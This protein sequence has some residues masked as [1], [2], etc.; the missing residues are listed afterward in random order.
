M[1]ELEH[2]VGDLLIRAPWHKKWNYRQSDVCYGTLI[3]IN[4]NRYTV[5]WWD[6]YIMTKRVVDYDHQ[7]IKDFKRI[8]YLWMLKANENR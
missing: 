5:H 4:N 7:Q 2:K 3:S 8:L 6:D 1:S